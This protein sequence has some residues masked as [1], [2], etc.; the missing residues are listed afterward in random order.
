MLPELSLVLTYQN[1]DVLSRYTKDY[2]ENGL[3]AH[4]VFP[5]LLKYL[6][7]TQKLQFDQFTNPDAES[8]KFKCAIHEEMKEIDD[9]WHTFILFTKNYADFCDKFFGEFIHHQPMSEEDKMPLDQFEV[10]LRRYLSYVYDNLGE[11]IVRNWF[12]EF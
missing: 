2:P 8:L 9:M 6:W 11:D 12:K 5:E 4:E 7:L 3:K 10:D 1:E